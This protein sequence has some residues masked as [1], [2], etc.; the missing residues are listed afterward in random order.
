MAT[1]YAVAAVSQA[2]LGLLA[3]A[4][5]RPEFENAKFE[6]F[7]FKDFQR[8]PPLAEGVSLY[9]Y[10][11]SVNATQRNLPPSIDLYG[12]T[13]QRPLPLDLH[14]MLSVWATTAVSQQRLLGWCMRTLEDTSTLSATLLNNYGRPERAF[15][16]AESVQLIYDPMSLQDT[17]ELWDVLK[18]N[19]QLS[20]TYTARVVYIESPLDLGVDE[21]VQS[22][23]LQMVKW[24]PA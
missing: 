9:L 15:G 24:P 1:L 18:P 10:R 8:T 2:I 12:H 16:P 23:E 20:V 13:L 4:R 17:I 19:I 14:Y 6:L 22:R 7:Q 21:P 11:V 5:P 3:D